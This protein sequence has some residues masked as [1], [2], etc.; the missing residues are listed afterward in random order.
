MV[1]KG[2]QFATHVKNE[3]KAASAFARTKT[4]QEQREYLPVFAVLLLKF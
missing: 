4:L 1:K 3:E 2:S